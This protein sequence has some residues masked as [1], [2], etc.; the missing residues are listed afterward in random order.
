VTGSRRFGVRAK[1]IKRDAKI[2]ET[3]CS[4]WEEGA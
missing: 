1:S 3:D 2:A 4:V